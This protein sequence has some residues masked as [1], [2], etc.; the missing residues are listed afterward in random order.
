MATMYAE[1]QSTSTDIALLYNKGS[2]GQYLSHIADI[3]QHSQQQ[4]TEN[5]AA[6]IW[7]M[8]IWTGVD[9][10]SGIHGISKARAVARLRDMFATVA[11]QS[12]CAVAARRAIT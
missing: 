10:T 8:C 2:S 3:L 7:A 1:R 12:A 11:M 4:F 9:T 6:C 5:G